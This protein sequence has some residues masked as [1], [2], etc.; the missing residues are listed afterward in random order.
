MGLTHKILSASGNGWETMKNGRRKPQGNNMSGITSTCSLVRALDADS[1][2]TGFEPRVDHLFDQPAGDITPPTVTQVA[3][4]VLLKAR[5]RRLGT[6]I[7]RVQEHH[8]GDQDGLDTHDRILH[9]IRRFA[10]GDW[11]AAWNTSPLMRSRVMTLWKKEEWKEVHS[12]GVDQRTLASVLEDVEGDRWTV[13]TAHFHT[14]RGKGGS[15]GEEDWLER[16]RRW[17]KDGF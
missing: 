2:G 1:E 9:G 11:G 17:A 7:I 15:N 5:T 12:F 4:W 14:R 10:R 6:G 8:Y 13:V 3:R 16:W